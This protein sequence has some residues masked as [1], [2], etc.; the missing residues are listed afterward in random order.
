MLIID[1]LNFAGKPFI[2]LK[3]ELPEQKAPILF[4]KSQVILIACSY[5]DIE[6]MDKM[7]HIACT[8]SGVNNFDQMM[9]STMS[10]IT[11]RASKK[12]AKEGMVVKEFINNL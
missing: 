5:F 3:V 4:L 12:G 9:D 10:E 11:T 7:D 1:Q 6:V 8:V 2:G